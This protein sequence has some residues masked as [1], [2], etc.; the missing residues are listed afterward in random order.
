[1]KTVCQE[2]HCS[3]YLLNESGPRAFVVSTPES[4]EICNDPLL[5]GAKYTE[6]LKT[7][8]ARVLPH[9]GPRLR[10]GE[11]SVVHLLRGGLNFGLREALASAFGWNAHYSTFLSAQRRRKPANPEEWEIG[12]SEY[13]KLA[14]PSRV[15]LVMGDVVASGASLQYGVESML[16][17]IAEQQKSLRSILFFTIGGPRTE[18]VFRELDPQIR[19]AHPEFEG[20][21]VVYFEGR[22][23]VAHP[24]T[25]L[26]IKITGTDLLR[27]GPDLAPE[28]IESQYESPMF[29]V[30]RCT[31]Y[32]AGTRAF[33]ADVYLDD[34]IEYWEEVAGLSGKNY[35]AYLEERLPGLDAERFSG[36]ESVAELASE[37]LSRLKA[38]RARFSSK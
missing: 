12:E 36:V 21:T 5:Y 26:T 32:D 16:Q 37:Q 8:C 15:S 28:F 13:R 11:T 4:R 31:I 7:A 10:E 1:V 34:V 24:E 27:H 9:V 3:V 29:P 38:E 35:Q 20:T 23:P 33:E 14:I 19:S 18:E 30:E 17:A 6:R 22:F 2:E 25:P